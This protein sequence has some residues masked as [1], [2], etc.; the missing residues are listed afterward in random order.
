VNFKIESD[1][2]LNIDVIDILMLNIFA[3]W[4]TSEILIGFE[5]EHSQNGELWSTFLRSSHGHVLASFH[6]IFPPGYFGG[7]K[8]P[9]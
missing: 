9:P 2:T 4:T 7:T 6:P 8:F 5:I 1:G 3:F